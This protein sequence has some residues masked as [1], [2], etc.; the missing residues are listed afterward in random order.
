LVVPL[1][2]LLSLSLLL[3]GVAYT[4][5]SNVG[6]TATGPIGSADFVDP[7]FRI[8]RRHDELTVAG[9]TAS[10]QHEIL[11]R[12]AARNAYPG[13]DLR[14]EFRPL[15]LVPDWWTGATLELLAALRP[16]TSPTALLGER[17][18]RI[19]ALVDEPLAMEPALESLA[20]RL[21]VTLD[22][23]LQLAPTG[24]AVPAK[25]LCRRQFD[26]FDAGSIRFEDVGTSLRMSAWPA[27]DRIIALADACRDATLTV[28]G[29]TDSTGD[30]AWNRELS[31]A[32]AEAVAAYLASRGVAASR[33]V[34]VGAGSA[35]PVADNGTRYGRSLN[36]RIEVEFAYGE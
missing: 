21:P 5:P 29:H 12:Q 22:V 9:H 31:R 30:D 4:L 13:I 34:T 2:R 3:A 8:E 24:P 10:Q 7:E 36:R 11:L 1:R 27:L 26:A 23:D 35:R 28:T 18:L 32:R 16:A 6:S 19:D 20:R 14:F 25:V 33:I 17:T 15:G